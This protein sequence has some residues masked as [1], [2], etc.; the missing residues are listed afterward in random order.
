[1]SHSELTDITSY[2]LLIISTNKYVSY[3]GIKTYYTLVVAL[4]TPVDI[5]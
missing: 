1:M 2:L 3:L 5:R 4:L